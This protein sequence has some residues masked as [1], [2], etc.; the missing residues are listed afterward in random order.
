[1]S[2]RRDYGEVQRWLEDQK[3]RR[4]EAAR[5]A[6]RQQRPVEGFSVIRLPS[7]ADGLDEVQPPPT[8][9]AGG[10]A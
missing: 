8:R 5:R 9:F 6:A 2:H 10:D 4:A 3:L 1:M 7:L